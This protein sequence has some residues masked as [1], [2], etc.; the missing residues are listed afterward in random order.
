MQRKI[1]KE[2]L[3]AKALR[4]KK[5]LVHS[6]RIKSKTRFLPLVL[7]MCRC[8][9]IVH[10]MGKMKCCA[11]WLERI[12]DAAPLLGLCSPKT[13]H[14]PSFCLSYHH[15]ELN[16]F[17]FSCAWPLLTLLHNKLAQSDKSVTCLLRRILMSFPVI[18]NVWWWCPLQHL[19]WY[20]ETFLMDRPGRGATSV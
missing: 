9:C 12:P 17:V 13:P 6:V 2:L 18:I 7:F 11:P 15:P 8:I 1:F 10:A 19:W 5:D 14:L 16:P 20:L 3:K 4:L